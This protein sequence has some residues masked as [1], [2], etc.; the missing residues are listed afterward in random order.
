MINRVLNS[1]VATFKDVRAV[2]DAKI[3]MDGLTVLCG[4]NSS[5]KTTISRTIQD[6]IEALLYLK[7]HIRHYI[8]T[9]LYYDVRRQIS[10]ILSSIGVD[11]DKEN[12]NEIGVVFEV[13]YEE[14]AGVFAGE[15]YVQDYIDETEDGD[16]ISV[17]KPIYDSTGKQVAVLG[18]DYNASAVLDKL[19]A[20]LGYL[21]KMAV[22]CAV[23][24]MALVFAVINGIMRSMKQVQNKMYDLVY[25]KGDLTQKL[26]VKTGDEMELIADGINERR[27]RIC[28]GCG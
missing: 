17:Y 18:C 20:M 22:I 21:V 8:L 10:N 27:K 15:E 5:G 23:V 9:D 14:L 16:L 12:A 3:I 25:N 13:P 2:S 1:F 7:M 4:K 6:V 24:A 19:D 11:A 28:C 26:D